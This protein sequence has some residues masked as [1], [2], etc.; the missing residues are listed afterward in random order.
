MDY[1]TFK[2]KI[3]DREDRFE[4]FCHLA[5]P[6]LVLK[7]EARKNYQ[8]AP[9]QAPYDGCTSGRYKDYEGKILFEYK[10]GEQLETIKH[11]LI[12]QGGKLQRAIDSESDA[13]VYVLVL[14]LAR[15]TQKFKDSINKFLKSNGYSLGFELIPP[16]QIRRWVKDNPDL[17]KKAFYDE[18]RSLEEFLQILKDQGAPVS[19]TQYEHL[20]ELFVS[21]REFKRIKEI[22]NQHQIV[23]IIGPPHTGKTFTA[24]YILWEYYRDYGRSPRWILP[25]SG[26]RE[27]EPGQSVQKIS[28]PQETLT[29]LIQKNIGSELITYLEDIFGRTSEEE[30]KWDYPKPEEIL[31]EII[32]NVQ[33]DNNFRIIITSRET[34]FQRALER[35]PELKKLVVKLSA[36]AQ[37][38]ISEQSY[39]KR[40]RINLLKNY[41][42]F[43]TCS[44]LENNKVPKDV[45]ENLDRLHTP[46]SIRYFCEIS[47]NA[48]TIKQREKCLKTAEQEL[49]K[50]FAHDFEKMKSKTLSV[51]LTIVFK[52]IRQKGP[53]FL[54]TAFPDITPDQAPD[55]WAQETS[56]L[57]NIITPEKFLP[58]WSHPDYQEAFYLVLEKTKKVKEIFFNMTENL[59]RNLATREISASILARSF[60]ILDPQRRS[61]LKTLAEDKNPEIRKTVAFVLAG[62]W[63][64]LDREGREFLKTLAEDKNPEFR[65]RVAFGLARN[66]SSLDG[67]G[68][69]LLRSLAGDPSP[70]VKE[71]V[72]S[73]LA[74]NWSFLDREGRAL[75]KSL[76]RDSSPEVRRW[77]VFGLVWNWSSL[78]GEDREFLRSLAGG[79]SPEVRGWVA[80]VLA[81][82]WSF[83]DREGRELLRSLAKDKN[84]E[85][86][87]EVASGVARN[88]Q[89]LNREDKELLKVLVKDKNPE[90]RRGVAFGLAWNWRELD[91]EGREL[92][93][94]LAKDR[95]PKVRSGVASG[96]AGNWQEPGRG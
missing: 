53:E 41:A 92:L 61:L 71:E 55:I 28:S 82:N 49:V 13:V 25:K 36:K 3:T 95:N 60:S 72:A 86:R 30:V 47:K 39:T 59:A 94:S 40:N 38:K 96:L 64:F 48:T 83:L 9:I 32:Y 8:K 43:Y 42:R 33:K 24:T 77:V 46:H 35:A 37:A 21:P 20:E 12:K 76:V 68:R 58:E 23:F 62:N 29:E 85:V 75:L 81:W 57:K 79:P 14:G 2:E 26:G 44:W 70:E 22:L 50:A 7:G 11:D 54:S 56:K 45:R 5:V 88:W 34:I 87:S 1:K 84:P 4:K 91:R 90:V 17:V 74:W 16:D 52:P 80:S 89:E 69:K 73:D 10:S 6:E 67:E 31:K 27:P 15:P 66:W 93:K 51:L 63:K 65:K 19:F 18:E 78:D